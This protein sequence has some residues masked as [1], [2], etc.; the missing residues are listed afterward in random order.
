MSFRPHQ[1]S[2]P[3]DNIQPAGARPAICSS[4]IIGADEATPTVRRP[5]CSHAS[6]DSLNPIEMAARRRVAD[7]RPRGDLSL[8]S[9]T[10]RWKGGVWN[11]AITTGECLLRSH[12]PHE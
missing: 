1:L 10:L 8:E 5:N 4:S 9:L 6:A 2:D 3:Q 7:G 12:R 11:T